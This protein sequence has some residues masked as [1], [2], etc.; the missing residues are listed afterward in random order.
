M[1]GMDENK[2][3]VEIMKR[4]GGGE[5]RGKGWEMEEYTVNKNRMI[6]GKED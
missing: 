1:R 4:E 3:R 6:K 5:Q 2:E